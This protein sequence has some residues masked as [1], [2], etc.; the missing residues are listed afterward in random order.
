M[1]SLCHP[2][3]EDIALVLQHLEDE[4]QFFSPTKRLFMVCPLSQPQISPDLFLQ[5][6]RTV[7]CC[8]PNA[9]YLYFKTWFKHHLLNVTIPSL[10]R[11]DIYLISSS[12]TESH[13]FYGNIYGLLSLTGLESA[14]VGGGRRLV[15]LLLCSQHLANRWRSITLND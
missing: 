12:N 13:L 7:I 6:R 1:R 15:I 5:L 2:T 4:A 14:W 8:P 9:S 3:V 11:G 10:Q